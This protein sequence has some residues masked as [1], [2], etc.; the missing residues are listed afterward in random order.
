MKDKTGH[1]EKYS[2]KKEMLIIALLTETSI[3]AAAK[4]AGISHNSAINW[5]QDPDFQN[6]YREA[7]RQ[8]VAQAITQ[9][10]QAAT[11]AVMT[12]KGV[13]VDEEATAAS[14]VSA[15]RTVL[16]TALKAIEIEDLAARIERLEQALREEGKLVKKAR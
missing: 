6:S 15:A 14:K 4:K 1:G 5:L 13:M 3:Q 9:V 16:D 8:A 10:Q 2:R 11:L 12:L 7:R